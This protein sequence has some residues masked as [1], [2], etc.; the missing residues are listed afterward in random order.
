MPK[1]CVVM[2]VKTWSSRCQS[3]LADHVHLA[4]TSVMQDGNEHGHVSQ[5]SN[6]A[7]NARTLIV[8]MPLVQVLQQLPCQGPC[9]TK[10]IMGVS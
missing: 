10:C 5:R 6:P 7:S 1:G 9:G 4:I 3:C 2:G 8:T